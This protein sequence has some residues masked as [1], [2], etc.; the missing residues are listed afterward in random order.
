MRLHKEPD[1]LP[2]FVVR[3][4]FGITELFLHRG[5]AEENLLR[6]INR[7]GGV[8]WEFAVRSVYAGQTYAA[9]LSGVGLMEGVLRAGVT[10]VVTIQ[11]TE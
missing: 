10:I 6:E 7:F 2:A 1:R 3:Y 4:G 11:D 8:L 5:F 9:E